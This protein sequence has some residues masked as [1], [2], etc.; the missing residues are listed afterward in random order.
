MKTPRVNKV[1]YYIQKKPL[2]AQITRALKQL[3]RFG[4]EQ[5]LSCLFP[6][7]IFASLAFTQIM[8]L[9]FL[10]RYDWLLIICLLIGSQA[11]L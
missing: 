1:G 6:V 11:S 7:V 8:P 5:A 9:P 4:W 10:P 2:R 3:I